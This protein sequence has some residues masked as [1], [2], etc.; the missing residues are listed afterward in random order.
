MATTAPEPQCYADRP[1]VV[2]FALSG[3][4]F[5][6][7]VRLACLAFE[8]ITIVASGL[9]SATIYV[10][11]SWSCANVVS[12]LLV[13]IG[14]VRRRQGLTAIGGC[15]LVVST[16]LLFVFCKACLREK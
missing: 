5:L 1:S 6:G 9:C 13:G 10:D 12:F 16:L 4:C 3:V 15:I 11:L 8:G 14:F 2:R 7:G